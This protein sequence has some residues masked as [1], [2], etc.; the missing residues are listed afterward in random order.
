MGGQGRWGVTD[1]VART[2]GQKTLEAISQPRD[3]DKRQY[4]IPVPVQYGQREGTASYA[5][6]HWKNASV[7][8]SVRCHHATLAAG[9]IFS[10][11][12]GHLVLVTRGLGSSHLGGA[13]RHPV[14]SR[15]GRPRRAHWAT[16]RTGLGSAH[17]R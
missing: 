7:R 3:G 6:R 5:P 4:G 11:A 17:D 10:L 13:A 8:Q 16:K 15:G 14:G 1:S 2:F 9:R 12:R